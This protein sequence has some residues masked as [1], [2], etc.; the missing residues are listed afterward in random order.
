MT[1]TYACSWC[2]PAFGPRVEHAE[3]E[4]CPK[5]G[6][7]VGI[8]EKPLLVEIQ[9]RNLVLS[10]SAIGDRVFTN[11]VAYVKQL[12]KDIANLA[13]QLAEVMRRLS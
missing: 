11:D 6:A 5:T 10:A 4:T 13:W 12:H 3:G 9:A 8:E 1:Q 7:T 2:S